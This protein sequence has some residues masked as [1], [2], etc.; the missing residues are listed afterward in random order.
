M[1]ASSKDS[2]RVEARKAG[3]NKIFHVSVAGRARQMNVG[4]KNAKGKILLFLHADSTLPS[5]W[6]NDV[7]GS[8]DSGSMWGSYETIDIGNDVCV[9]CNYVLFVCVGVNVCLSNF[10]TR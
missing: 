1:D 4:A 6:I 2:T 7:K 9:R 10:C 5:G 8:I 3:A